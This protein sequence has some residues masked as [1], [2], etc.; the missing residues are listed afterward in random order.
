LTA[1]IHTSSLGM[2]FASVRHA[3]L[4]NENM[5]KKVQ[6]PV[7]EPGSHRWQWCILPRDH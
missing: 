5:V 7:I 6:Q 4:E 2:M 1:I 3:E